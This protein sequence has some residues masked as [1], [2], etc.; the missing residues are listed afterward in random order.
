MARKAATK[1]QA[2]E[3]EEAPKK[4]ERGTA[5]L[6]EYVNEEC[7][8]SHS[9]ATIR[10]LLRKLVKEGVLAREVGEDRSRYTFAKGANDPIVK[11]VVKAVKSGAVK[12]Q[13]KEKLD[14]LKAKKAA[15]PKA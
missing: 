11:A 6:T 10:I 2:E 1:V 4:I 3:V 7:G 14:E 8:T 12:E 5:W 15:A 9:A 13:Q